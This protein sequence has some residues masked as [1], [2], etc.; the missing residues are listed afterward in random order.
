MLCPRVNEFLEFRGLKLNL[1]KTVITDISKGF[2]YLGYH[3][4][5]YSNVTRAKGTKKGIFLVKP[6]RK[7]INRFKRSLRDL[8]RV[9]RNK[10][11]NYQIR[12]F[13]EKLR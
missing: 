7:N 3:F 11:I 5:E 2:G 12:K 6:S 9:I 10:D 13:N 4:R 8:L 1:A